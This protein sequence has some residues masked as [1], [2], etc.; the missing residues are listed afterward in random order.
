VCEKAGTFE[1]IFESIS[2]AAAAFSK[3]DS[4]GYHLQRKRF[5]NP[6]TTSPGLFKVLSNL[7]VHE[8]RNGGQPVA[9][10]CAGERVYVSR[11]R[12]RSARLMKG[13]NDTET[14]GWAYLFTKDGQPLLEQ[15][16][17]L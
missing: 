3:K 4:I 5:K 10:K 15:V 8:E 14:L 16:A 7:T 1:V 2:K 6:K 13:I 11:I 17:A 9:K 12:G